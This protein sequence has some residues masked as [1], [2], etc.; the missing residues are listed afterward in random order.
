MTENK[1][2]GHSTLHLTKEHNW[3]ENSRENDTNNATEEEEEL[4]VNNIKMVKQLES[5]E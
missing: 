4:R 3:H 5:T 2:I 1:I